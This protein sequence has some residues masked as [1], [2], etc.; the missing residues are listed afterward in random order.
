MQLRSLDCSLYL[1][2]C[3]IKEQIKRYVKE[4]QTEDAYKE[5]RLLHIACVTRKQL[6]LEESNIQTTMSHKN[7]L[8]YNRTEFIHMVCL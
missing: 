7:I 5:R 1:R 3:V 6:N 4:A 2:D 8:F